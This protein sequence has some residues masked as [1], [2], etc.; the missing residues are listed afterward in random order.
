MVWFIFGGELRPATAWPFYE[1]AY[2][3]VFGKRPSA[4]RDAFKKLL[5]DV[6]P[7]AD[8]FKRRPVRLVTIFDTEAR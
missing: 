2:A 7:I 1:V 4:D 6:R 8:N 5:R 3:Y